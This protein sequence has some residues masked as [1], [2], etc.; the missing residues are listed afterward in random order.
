MQAAGTWSTMSWM[1]WSMSASTPP[2]PGDAA[3]E[4]VAP[5]STAAAIGGMLKSPPG[6]YVPHSRSRFGAATPQYA[7]LTSATALAERE[8]ERQAAI[9]DRVARDSLAAFTPRMALADMRA[10][11]VGAADGGDDEEAASPLRGLAMWCLVAALLVASM[12]W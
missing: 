12:S 11:A 1:P 8:R 5:R 2:P 3:Y 9:A 6:P 7:G 10:A 4:E